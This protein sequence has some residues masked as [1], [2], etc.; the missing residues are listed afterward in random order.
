MTHEE[1]TRY[2][3]VL[4]ILFE[5]EKQMAVIKSRLKALEEQN[6]A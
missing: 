4:K 6:N 3:S 1:L 5:L 2:E